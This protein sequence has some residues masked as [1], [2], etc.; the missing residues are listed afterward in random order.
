MPAWFATVIFQLTE[1]KFE[2]KIIMNT[3]TRTE[4]E[5]EINVKMGIELKWKL[6]LL[7]LIQTWIEISCWTEIISVFRS[8]N[9]HKILATYRFYLDSNL[10]TNVNG[11]ETTAPPA[12]KK[13]KYLASR[14]TEQSNTLSAGSSIDT[15]WDSSI[16]TLVM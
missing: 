7:N 5:T 10:A 8:K 4:I 3:L 13:F 2:R 9:A 16:D 1:T 14:M 11:S 15:T 6:I 12:L